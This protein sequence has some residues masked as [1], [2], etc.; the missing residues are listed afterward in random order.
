MP[1]PPRPSSASLAPVDPRRQ[2]TL[3]D[4]LTYADDV[5]RIARLAIPLS[6]RSV[7]R[8]TG[9]RYVHRRA[10]DHVSR[11]GRHL[12]ESTF[13]SIDRATVAYL[14]R[15]G[16][17]APGAPGI[18]FH[19]HLLD[20]TGP[21][22]PAL[23]AGILDPSPAGFDAVHPRAAFRCIRRVEAGHPGYRVHRHGALAVVTGDAPLAPCGDVAPLPYGLASVVLFRVPLDHLAGYRHLLRAVVHP[24]AALLERDLDAAEALLAPV[25]TLDWPVQ[26]EPAEAGRVA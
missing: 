9:R 5:Y 7:E 19:L 6:V 1:R 15:P 20:A 26:H 18:L 21:V 14:P 25:A 22:E 24:L 3:A 10:W 16:A 17:S 12:L 13:G 2:G 11:P 23:M 4:A 8:A